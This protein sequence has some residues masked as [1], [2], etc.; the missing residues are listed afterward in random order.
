A[1][2]GERPTSVTLDGI[3][4][5]AVT[6]PFLVACRWD[7]D[8]ATASA[9]RWAWAAA[10]LAV[11]VVWSLRRPLGPRAGG[12]R[13]A[14]MFSL[15]QREAIYAR[16]VILAAASLS[17]LVVTTRVLIGLIGAGYPPAG[18]AAGS[19]FARIGPA[20]SDA[21]PLIVLAASFA[22]LA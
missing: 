5:A 20:M 17:I 13:L 22:L 9:L 12:L 1:A 7:V 16:N 19:F 18:P 15:S 6:V 11:A 2:H 10:A 4:L 3:I 14:K 21:V 8:L